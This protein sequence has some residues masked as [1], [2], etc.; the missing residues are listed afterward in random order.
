MKPEYVEERYEAQRMNHEF[1]R[2]QIRQKQRD[3]E[4]AKLTGYCKK[5]RVEFN[6]WRILGLA[7]C[8]AI[9]VTT[10]ALAYS[11]ILYLLSK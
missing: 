6:Y 7:I 1:L 8:L 5:P 2:A 11:G 3:S 9:G 10:A 4:W